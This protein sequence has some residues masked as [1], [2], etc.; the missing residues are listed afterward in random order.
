MRIRPATTADAAAIATI[1]NQGIADRVATLETEPRSAEER[2]AWLAARGA[3]YPVLVATDADGAVAG[4]GALN[5]FNPRP[6]YDHVAEFSLY[7]ARERRG[8]GI[9][10]ALLGALEERARGL[11]FHKLV[12]SA[13]A[14]NTPGLRLYQRHGFA[15]V[16]IYREQ[17][18][19]DGRWV[20]TMVMEKLLG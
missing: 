15:L 7:V 6:A 12:L 2:A 11:G 14:T 1:Y 9:G 4:W 18:L 16:G 10:G 5:Q 17:G 8:Q 3:R 20:D 19:L 13:F